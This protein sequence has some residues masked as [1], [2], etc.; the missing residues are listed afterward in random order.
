MKKRMYLIAILLLVLVLAGCAPETPTPAPATPTL[1]VQDDS[2]QKVQQAG[3]LRVGTTGDYPPFE[4]Y[5]ENLQLD[6]F[7]IA[8]IQQIGEKLGLK[9]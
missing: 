3:V 9:V 7:D 5:N 4:Y 2:W 1:A 8:L 6:G